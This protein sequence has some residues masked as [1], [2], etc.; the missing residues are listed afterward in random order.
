M[1][2]PLS[3]LPDAY[4]GDTRYLWVPGGKDPNLLTDA[5]SLRWEPRWASRSRGD[6]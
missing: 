6:M 5:S 2:Q 3:G 4:F 1:I